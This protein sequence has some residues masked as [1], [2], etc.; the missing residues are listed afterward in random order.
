M[1]KKDKN[2]LCRLV[3]IVATMP[4]EDKLDF[5]D[6]FGDYLSV[7]S[8]MDL[9]I[10]CEDVGYKERYI[11]FWRGE[12]GIWLFDYLCSLSGDIS[13]SLD[14]AI[15]YFV[16]KIFELVKSIDNIVVQNNCLI[17]ILK[18]IIPSI[19]E[20]VG[21]DY[22]NNNVFNCYSK[23]LNDVL[24]FFGVDDINMVL[25]SVKE[26]ID[27]DTELILK[28]GINDALGRIEIGGLANGEVID[29]VTE[30]L[31]KNE[32]MKDLAF[33]N[34]L[35]DRKIYGGND[36]LFFLVVDILN[37]LYIIG[38]DDLIEKTF[39]DNYDLFWKYVN[40]FIICTRDD[41]R[42]LALFDE[43]S[44]IAFD[45]DG[46]VDVFATIG[47]RLKYESIF[48]K[49]CERLSL[50][51]KINIANRQNDSELA[52][53]LFSDNFTNMVNLVN[54]GAKRVEVNF[55]LFR[56]L[57]LFDLDK[58]INIVD[59][60]GEYFAD[61]FYFKVLMLMDSVEYKRQFIEDNL[62]SIRN[63][64]KSKKRVLN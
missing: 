11:E 38:N 17:K 20:L 29:N 32:A 21:N 22:F 25:G 60:Y 30:E 44:D 6:E 53:V 4:K 59:M 27:S 43:F 14:N 34:N 3:P 5:L 7:S 49:Y 39:R 64:I 13:E 52:D 63:R 48:G 9:I 47:D 42:K 10:A 37:S 56:L 2:M 51:D 61:D 23:Y 12:N 55:S 28:R 1:N 62:W 18:D 16:E 33:Y 15:V 54:D 41:E 40:Y 45:L 36:E 57:K 31:L 26:C 58:Q 8:Y 50:S 24:L 35:I 46:Y 19:K